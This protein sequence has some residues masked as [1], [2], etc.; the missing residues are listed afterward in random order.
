M[1]LPNAH[2][3]RVD[4]EKVVGYLLCASHPDGRAKARFF[5][6]FG[7]SV[8]EWWVFADA[9]KEHGLVNEVVKVLESDWG[10]RY[11]VDGELSAPDGRKPRV[12][13]VWIVERGQVTARLVTAHP[14]EALI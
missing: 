3:G 10:K 7:F 6:R 8:S 5:A 12:R 1:K 2:V 14:L 4:K 13:T 11:I 9:L